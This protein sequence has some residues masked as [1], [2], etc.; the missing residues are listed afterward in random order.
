LRASSDYDAEKGYSPFFHAFLADLPRLSSGNACTLL[1]LTLLSKSAGRGAKRGDA[2]PEWTL[3]LAVCDL[4]QICCCDERTIERELKALDERGLAEVR[5]PAKGEIEARLKFR[6]WEALPDYKSKVIEIPPAED[7]EEEDENEAAVNPGNQRV[8][9]KKPVR[10]PAGSSSKPF[11]VSCGVKSFRH[12]VEGPVDLEFRCV[13]QAG[14]LLVVSRFPDDWREKVENCKARS[15]EINDLISP[16]RHGCRG[17]QKGLPTNEG[18][19]TYPQ[20][21]VDHPR[22]AE[23]VQLFDPILARSASRLIG[24]DSSSLQAAC[25]AVG[26]CD[27]DYLV[28]FAVQRAER[29]VNSPLHVAKICSDALKSWQASKAPRPG[30]ASMDEIRKIIAKERAERL[31]KK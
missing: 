16:P 25:L 2:R 1:I 6:D 7:D 9:G 26:D 21:K 30:E 5:R 23:L 22:A 13:I 4:A 10:L 31:S 29:P 28:K 24:A 20:K 15:N 17:D 3:S 27:H 19:K 14:E 11:P 18:S 8:T 12:Q